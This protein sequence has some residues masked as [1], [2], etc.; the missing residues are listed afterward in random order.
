MAV[1]A[2]EPLLS[3]ENQMP[4]QNL[5]LLKECAARQGID[6]IGSA[7]Y[8]EAS[9]EKAKANISLI[10]DIA[11]EH[12][13]NNVDFHLDYN[14]DARTEP[15][16]YEVIRQARSRYVTSSTIEQDNGPKTSSP[17]V[18]GSDTRK[19]RCPHVTI[20]HATRLQLFS[21]DE[22][23]ALA[24][25]IRDLPITFV[26]LPQSD[27]YM[28]GRAS[29]KDPLGAPRGT[30]RVP[31]LA[32]EY[33]IHIAMSVNNIENAF[34]PQGSLDPLS[35]CTFGVAIFQAATPRDIAELVVRTLY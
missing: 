16:I 9:I 27:I 23:H 12:Q 13:F 20:G 29:K 19:R 26:G 4:S 28:Q 15:L 33:G 21:K 25:E 3:S 6:V 17:S 2:Q 31:D 35:L 22:W 30:L 11:D 8:V 5:L 10:F 7:P 18:T 34:T 24:N 14:L 1:F 32:R